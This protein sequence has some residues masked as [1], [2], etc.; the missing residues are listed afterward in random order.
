[1]PDFQG[2]IVYE[3]NPEIVAALEAAGK[4]FRAVDYEH[5]YPHC[6]RCDTAL[7]YYA[8]STWYI[9]TSEVRER[10]LAENERIGWHPEHIKHGRFGKWLEGNVDWALSRDPLLGHAAADLG[11]RGR[12]SCEERFCAGSVQDL[13]E[14]GGEVREDL[15]R[16]F[17][18]EIVARAASPAAARCGA[19]RR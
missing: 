8:K 2:K 4:L 5:A 16:P 7:L 13:R 11:V 17:V 9:R 15:H 18:D 19:S 10:M 12:R 6:W 3:H 14:R 1:M